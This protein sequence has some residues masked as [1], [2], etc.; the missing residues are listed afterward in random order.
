MASY[1]RSSIP[2]A[3]RERIVERYPSGKKKQAEYRLKGKVVGTRSFY[4][5]GEPE[6]EYGLRNGK[7]HG[8]HYDWPTPGK[9]G[10]V[11]P[12][13]DGVPHGTAKQWSDHG[14]LLG[15]Y[16]MNRGTGIDLWR[17]QRKDGSV[18]LSEARFLKNGFVCGFE[19]YINEDQQRVDSEHHY[20]GKVLHGICREW[21]AQGR[22]R[23]GYPQY[24]V[25][26]QKLTKQQYL[27]A[28]KMDPTLPPFRVKD[29]KPSRIFPKEIARELRP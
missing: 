16:T 22:L 2:K 20:N 5:T 7:K 1:Y 18:F 29:N 17:C 23:R 25:N 14:K 24:Y 10:F 19:W 9:L 27:R 28:S 26:H 15:T 6:L 11:E 21:N 4:E 8:I 3:A 12:Y 13:V